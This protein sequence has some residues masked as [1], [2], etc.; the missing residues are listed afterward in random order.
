MAKTRAMVPMIVY[1]QT[2]TGKQYFIVYYDMNDRKWHIG[3]SSTD[4]ELVQ[5]WLR[6]EF[7]I[8]PMEVIEDDMFSVTAMTAFVGGHIEGVHD[9]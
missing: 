6:T 9:A 4:L 2:S 3:Y 5:K 1:T 8:V 7:D